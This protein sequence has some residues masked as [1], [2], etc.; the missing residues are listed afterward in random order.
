VDGVGTVA[1]RRKPLGVQTFLALAGIGS[2]AQEINRQFAPPIVV[3]SG[4]WFHVILRVP[5][6]AAT[7]LL[8]F[9]GIVMV[10][11]FFE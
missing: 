9:R 7:A 6:G 3:D 10:H 5:D 1:P 11:G 4:R 8:V 2:E